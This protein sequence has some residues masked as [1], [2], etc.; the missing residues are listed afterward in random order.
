MAEGEASST[1]FPSKTRLNQEHEDLFHSLILSGDTRVKISAQLDKCTDASFCE[2]LT[3]SIDNSN[4][5][6]ETQGLQ[7]LINLI[8]E[9]NTE[10]AEQKAQVEAEATK[11]ATDKEEMEMKREGDNGPSKIMSNAEVLNQLMQLIR[12]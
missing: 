4:D 3:I 12:P 9:V 11:A 6:E 1:T 10:V 7:E 2:Y 5:E 8:Q